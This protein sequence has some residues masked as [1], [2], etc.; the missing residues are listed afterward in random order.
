MMEWK[1]I[2]FLLK[3]DTISVVIEKLPTVS[4]ENSASK[5][6]WV[7]EFIPILALIV[8]FALTIYTVRKNTELAKMQNNLNKNREFANKFTSL[9]AE[10]ITSSAFLVHNLRQSR[11]SKKIGYSDA[12][13]YLQK[14]KSDEKCIDYKFI[15]INLILNIKIK[16]QQEFK[17]ELEALNNNISELKLS[18]TPETNADEVMGNIE[19]IKIKATRIVEST[20]H[21]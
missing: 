15:E 19:K 6:A 5:W 1:G 3:N 4:I 10:Y 7:G 20:Y 16:E 14:A 8:S 13:E 18:D 9:F 17:I 11:L 2:P 12:D 21:N